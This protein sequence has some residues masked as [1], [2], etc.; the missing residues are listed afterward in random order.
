VGAIN[1][2][3]VRSGGDMSAGQRIVDIRHDAVERRDELRLGQIRL[4]LIE[5]NL[6]ASDTCLG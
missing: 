4:G 5:C 1:A 6:R 3:C 2:A